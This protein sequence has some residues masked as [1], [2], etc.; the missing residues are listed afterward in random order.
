M[1]KNDGAVGM[2]A[3]SDASTRCGRVEA[4]SGPDGVTGVGA[5]PRAT[6]FRG[7]ISYVCIPLQGWKRTDIRNIMWGL[8]TI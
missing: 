6:H 4:V 5:L 8:I 1:F 2:I 7:G 3:G